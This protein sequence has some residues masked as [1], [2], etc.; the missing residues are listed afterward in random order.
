MQYYIHDEAE[1]LRMWRL[2]YT[3]KQI[4]EKL[5]YH[6]STINGWRTRRGLKANGGTGWGG[7]RKKS[8]SY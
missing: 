7:R 2:G 1:R 5:M 3:D 6:E 4:A 8:C